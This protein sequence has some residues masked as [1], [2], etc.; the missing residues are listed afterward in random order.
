MS[1]QEHQHKRKSSLIDDDDDD[2]SDLF[3]EK[4]KAKRYKQS[5]L[6]EFVIEILFIL[7]QLST[8]NIYNLSHT[9]ITHFFWGGETALLTC[10]IVVAEIL[11]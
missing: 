4:L 7:L 5:D 9:L 6:T 1:K 11:N 3:D 8:L 2:D 10:C